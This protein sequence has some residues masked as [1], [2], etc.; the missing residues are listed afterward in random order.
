MNCYFY[1]V[2]SPLGP[3]KF[4]FECSYKSHLTGKQS[5]LNLMYVNLFLQRDNNGF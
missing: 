3:E 2:L 5:K 4:P 1:F